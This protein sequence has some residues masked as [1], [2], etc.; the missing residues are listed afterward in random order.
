MKEPYSDC[1]GAEPRQLEDR[2]RV[3]KE[4][5]RINYVLRRIEK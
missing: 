1:D 4:L 2:T 3:P 5:D